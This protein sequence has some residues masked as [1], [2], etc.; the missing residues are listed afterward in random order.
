MTL[1]PE[2]YTLGMALKRN[3]C[4]M[5]CVTNWQMHRFTNWY[6]MHG[7]H[8]DRCTHAH[9]HY[10]AYNQINNWIL[11]DWDWHPRQSFFFKKKGPIFN[12]NIRLLVNIS[13]DITKTHCE[14]VSFYRNWKKRGEKIVW[15][16]TKEKGDQW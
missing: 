2:G 3:A 11:I 4:T 6:L 12:Q 15:L 13:N 1:R 10:N 14:R 5:G 9:T 8:I 16:K 7:S